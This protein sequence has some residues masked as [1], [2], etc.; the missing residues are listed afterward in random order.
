MA[1]AGLPWRVARVLECDRR[2]GVDG[3]VMRCVQ[4]GTRGEGGGAAL[5]PKRQRLS[6]VPGLTRTVR[7]Q[8]AGRSWQGTGGGVPLDD[9]A[10]DGEGTAGHQLKDAVASEW[11]QPARLLRLEQSWVRTCTPDRVPA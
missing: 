4:H 2:T 11:S 5:G 7:H 6:G 3:V 1:T 9:V 10:H 8:V